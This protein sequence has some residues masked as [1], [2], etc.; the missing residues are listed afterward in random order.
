LSD[1]QGRGAQSALIAARMRTAIEAGCELL[2]AETGDEKPGEHNTSLR[3]LL[4][5]GFRVLYKRRNW[6]WRA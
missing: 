3:N 5:L 4:R 1:F 2:V 6:I